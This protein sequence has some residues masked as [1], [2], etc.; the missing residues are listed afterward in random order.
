[1]PL[2]PGEGGGELVCLRLR[3]REPRLSQHP[4]RRLGSESFPGR[5]GEESGEER[6]INR[7]L[8]RAL[9]EGF[10]IVLREGAYLLGEG[11]A[12]LEYHQGG[13]GDDAELGG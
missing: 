3:G 6:A 13:D 10:D 1:M 2:G 12:A 5:S 8:E 7:E 11:L 9:D 4:S